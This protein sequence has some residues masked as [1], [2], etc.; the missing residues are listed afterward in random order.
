MKVKCRECGKRYDYDVYSGICPKCSTYNAAGGDNRSQD[1]SEKGTDK[2]LSPKSFV[3]MTG[4]LGKKEYE[5]SEAYK[6]AEVSGKHFVKGYYVATVI[7]A[8]IMVLVFVVPTFII[9]FAIKADKA[10]KRL[11]QDVEPIQIDFGKKINVADASSS[12]AVVIDGIGVDEE[13]DYKL[14][15][16]YEMLRIDFHV[17]NDMEEASEYDSNYMSTADM[18][19]K[20]D[21]YINTEGN[22]YLEA[23]SR[24][25]IQEALGIS[26]EEGE[27]RGITEIF[28]V[29]NGHMYYIV[30][31]GDA[32]G[33][34]ISCVDGEDKVS[35]YYID[36][37]E[38]TGS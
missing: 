2:S 6:M 8:V 14:T 16:E 9:P 30:K 12:M 19:V 3:D 10:G 24:F 35:A 33:I 36:T 21:M 28:D 37:Q 31:K 18:A 17:E 4:E 29:R 13:A 5:K 15:K 7:L 34:W 22:R 11:S 32:K 26:Y 38:V 25:D 1:Y 27:D 20:L 23:V